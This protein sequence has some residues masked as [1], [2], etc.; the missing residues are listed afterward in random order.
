M[1]ISRRQFGV[2]GLAMASGVIGRANAQSYA[3]QD[4]HFICGFAPGSGSDLMVRHFAE[5]MRPLLG[6]NVIVE[7]KPGA[8][9]NIATEYVARA[10]P[11]GHTIYL[12]SAGVLAANQNTLKKPTVDLANALQSFGTMNRNPYMVAVPGNSPYKS[13]AELTAAMKAKGDKASYGFPG[14]SASKVIG[15]LYRDMAGLSSV[16]VPYRTTVDMLNDLKGGNLDYAILEPTAALAQERQGNLRILVITTS[17]RL[18]FL[19]QYQTFVEAGLPIRVSGWWAGFVPS[20]TPRPIIEELSKILASVTSTEET[21][22]F[23]ANI[24]YDVWLTPPNEAQAY[25]RQEIK[26]WADYVRVAKI[27][28]T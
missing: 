19:P 27:E 5:K 15:A 6:R 16:E 9:S 3:T 23:L 10:K 13:L 24:G 26:D 25:L 7:N 11:D 18:K 2:M 1:N 14:G 21:R 22:Q 4:V 8:F 20:A 28:Q 12:A 17:E